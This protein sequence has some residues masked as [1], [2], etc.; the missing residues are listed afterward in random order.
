MEDSEWTCGNCTLVND[1]ESAR[2]AA[3]ETAKPVPKKKKVVEEEEE[4]DEEMNEDEEEEYV[5]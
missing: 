4:E 1:A 3:C 5:V 2:C